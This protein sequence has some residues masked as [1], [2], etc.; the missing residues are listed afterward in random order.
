MKRVTRGRPKDRPDRLPVG[1]WSG[2]SS[3]RRPSSSTP[4]PTRCSS[5]SS[6]RGCSL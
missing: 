1:G 6:Q 5:R 2:T 3:T 4:W